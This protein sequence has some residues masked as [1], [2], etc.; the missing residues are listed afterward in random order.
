MSRIDRLLA[1]MA[2]LRDPEGGCPWDLEQDFASISPH[3]IEEAYEVD[4]AIANGDLEALRDELGDLLF[5]VVFQAR[6]AEE[7]DAFDFQGVVEAIIDKLVRRHPHIFADAETPATAEGQR[8]NWEEIKAAERAA[9]GGSDSE[10][11]DPFAGIPRSLPA[12]ARSA[13]ITGRIDRL[14]AGDPGVGPAS[15]RAA[16]ARTEKATANLHALL[17]STEGPAAQVSDAVSSKQEQAHAIGLALQGWV[18][19]ARRLGIEPEQA[20]RA[21]DDERIASIRAA[22][23]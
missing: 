10:E 1:I 19:V 22:S 2:R 5:Q 15:A 20:L 17:D 6:L 14:A 18:E 9:A 7:Q 11:T 12:L 23:R 21:V 8:L 3:T 13:K 4:D 16:L